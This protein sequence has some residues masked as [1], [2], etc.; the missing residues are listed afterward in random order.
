MLCRPPLWTHDGWLDAGRV[1]RVRKED[2]GR[3]EV[4]GHRRAPGVLADEPGEPGAADAAPTSQDAM[5]ITAIR[6]LHDVGQSIEAL[7]ARIDAIARR[8][9]ALLRAGSA[10]S[11][12]IDEFAGHP[13]SS[14]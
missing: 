2:V 5:T 12:I 10:I 6:H 3:G 7:E 13:R 9:L 11:E 8:T 4:R 1:Y 14:P